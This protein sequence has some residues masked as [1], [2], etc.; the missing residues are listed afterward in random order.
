MNPAP[1]D[2]RSPAETVGG[3]VYFGRM[4]DKIRLHA[5]GRLPDDLVENLG[6]GFDGR[7]LHFLGVGYPAVVE[8]VRQGGEDPAILEWCFNQGRRPDEEDIEIW[9]NFM[10]RRGLKDEGTP[11]LQRRKRESGLEARDDIETM[12]QYLDADEG[13]AVRPLP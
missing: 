2:L 10:Q 13:R 1:P 7:C 3:I 8:R 6:K 11:T 4:I 9:N 12:F 5:A